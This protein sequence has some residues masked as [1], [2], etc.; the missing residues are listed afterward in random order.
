MPPPV[1]GAVISAA[2]TTVG[3][4]IF[5]SSF[6][7]GFTFLG[8]TGA[9]A[10]FAASFA[11][12]AATGLVGMALAPDMKM[13]ATASM[14][15]RDQMLRQSTAPRKLVYGKVKIS[16]PAIF[17]QTTGK[18]E[19]LHMVIALGTHEFHAI[20]EV[21]LN[22][23]SLTLGSV[24]SLGMQPVTAPEQF[25]GNNDDG[26]PHIKVQLKLGT[27]SDA[28]FTELSQYTN[29]KWN[30][31][32]KLTNIPAIYARLA[33]SNDAYPNGIPNIS[34][35]VR[36]KKVLDTRTST[37]A[38][39]DNPALI[40][41]DYLTSEF[42]LNC[43]AS[44]INTTSFNTAA[45]VCEE[46]VSLAA[47]GTESRY[48]ANGVILTTDTPENNIKHLLASMGGILTYSNG[49]FNVRA[50]AYV[51]PSDTLT[52]D[53]F[54]GSIQINT[55]PSRRNNFNAVKGQWI[56]EDTN[57]QLADYPTI[58]SSTFEAEDGERIFRELDLPFTNS[59]A[60]AQR[61]AKLAL[62]RNR[63]QL[64]LSGRMK[65][66]AFKY[67]VGDTINITIDRY[68]FSSKV[69]EITSWALAV[70]GGDN[71]S[72]GVDVTMRELVSTVFDWTASVDEQDFTADNTT[73][74]SPFDILPC[75]VTVTDEL[76]LQNET[77]V[78]VLIVNVTSS[79]FLAQ[80]FEVSVKRN[81]DSEFIFLGRST[82][83][84]FEF[85]NALDG[86]LYNIRA[87]SIN[88]AGGV[89]A[90]TT[91]NHQV[92]GGTD[93]PSD[94]TNFAVN[95]IGKEAHLSWTPVTDIDLSHYQIRHSSATSGAS[96][97]TAQIFARK[98]SRPANTVVVPAQTGT[99]LIKAFDKG[100]RQSQNATESVCI[101]NEIEAGNVVSTITESPTFSG[102][103][104][105]VVVVDGALQLDTTINFDS[106][107]SGTGNFDDALGLFDGG[108]SS[109]ENEG[110]YSFV[111]QT[112]EASVDLGSKFTSRVTAILTT[113]RRDYVDLFDSEDG[114]FDSKSGLF[115]GDTAPSDV[116]VKLQVSTTDG[117]PS[118]SPSYSAFR[119]FVVGEYSA[120]AFRFRAVLQSESTNS[121]PIVT[122]LQVTVD[123][124]DRIAYQDDVVSGTSGSGKDITFTP[125]FKQ[126]DNLAITAQ[127]MA[128]GDFYVITNKSATGFNIIF[129]DSSS[130]PVSRT[131]D[132]AAKGFGEVVS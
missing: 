108:S 64:Q 88:S 127:N 29:N 104:S 23:Y 116:N 16:G 79:D 87:R 49:Q 74:R 35:V 46:S 102:T 129:R 5:A 43:D 80:E 37:T 73:L 98:V 17:M 56:A 75:G 62:F 51:S 45:N 39:S 130:N 100:G 77:P 59:N 128:S 67:D 24:E 1:V 31:T 32:H 50:G 123:M 15:G 21:Y 41:Y 22:E 60:T 106:G 109:V 40:L 14:K 18:S 131:F 91:V 70:E 115:D 55:K 68:G 13:P 58:T 122:A 4:S 66:T 38:Y 111:G 83:K 101:I 112:G 96:F 69:F 36:G 84:K 25:A 28:E 120:R 118:G 7:A 54:V 126:L 105:D 78:T 27:S 11:L 107:L 53:D 34:A 114:N 86:E 57:W 52:D 89:S 85:V 95:I 48:T 103:K 65:L 63:Q 99:Y 20:D 6:V 76:R 81:V 2:V 92:V 33:Y 97:Q 121:T 72:L 125:A 12:S 19:Y 10:V 82:N 61:L 3:A 44:E 93:I 9:T 110:T 42:G 47:G 26:R 30:N 8:L 113:D 124:P 90:Y 71:P 94:V 119:D 132:V 117:D